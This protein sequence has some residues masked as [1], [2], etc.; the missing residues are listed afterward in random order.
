M[1]TNKDKDG[2]YVESR[3][4]RARRRCTRAARS[5]RIGFC[6]FVAKTQHE[7]FINMEYSEYIMFAGEARYTT[8]MCNGATAE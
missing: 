2:S 7:D 1:K 8:R 3:Q 6:L 5:P 4:G